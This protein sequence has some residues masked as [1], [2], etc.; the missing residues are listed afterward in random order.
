MFLQYSVLCGLLLMMT[1]DIATILNHQF[2][3]KIS[4]SIH[5][6]YTFQYHSTPLTE[7]DSRL[8]KIDR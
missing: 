5:L 1:H 8:K 7:W 6:K 2:P 3:K 4:N